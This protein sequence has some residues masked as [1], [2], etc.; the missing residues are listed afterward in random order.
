MKINHIKIR[1]PIVITCTRNYEE[2]GMDQFMQGIQ[3]YNLKEECLVRH[4][5][6]DFFW[7]FDVQNKVL[8]LCQ[9]EED[10]WESDPDYDGPLSLWDNLDLQHRMGQ[11]LRQ[12][13]DVSEDSEDEEERVFGRRRVRGKSESMLPT[14]T[15]LNKLL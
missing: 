1:W 15:L 13:Q 9:L 7:N 14:L 8:V 11:Y 12:S 6:V 10:F 5:N 4:I 3:L 2:W